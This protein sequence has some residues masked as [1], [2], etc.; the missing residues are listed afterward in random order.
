MFLKKINIVLILMFA[1]FGGAISFTSFNTNKVNAQSCNCANGQ[2]SD[3]GCAANGC[4][5]GTR[6]V[7]NCGG[8]TGGACT[9]VYTSNPPQVGVWSCYCNSDASCNASNPPV[10]PPPGGNPPVNPPPGNPPPPACSASAPG[11]AVL[12]TPANGTTIATPTSATLSWN[13]PASW[14]TGCPQNNSYRL[15]T[16]ANCSGVYV[17]RGAAN[18][19]VNLTGLSQN[20]QY[21]WYV[22]TNNGS[23][24]V[25]SVVW[26]FRTGSIPT[27]TNNGFTMADVCGRAAVGRP[28]GSNVTN[29]ISIRST[30]TSSKTITYFDMIFV[31]VPRSVS[32]NAANIFVNTAISQAVNSMSFAMAVNG[33]VPNSQ[34]FFRNAAAGVGSGPST[35]G[36]LASPNNVATAMNIGSGTR[37][38][39]AGN[40]GTIDMQVRLENNFG[41]G[42]TNPTGLWDLY[43]IAAVNH[44]DGTSAWSNESANMTRIA[45]LTVDM[46]LPSASIVGPTYNANG[47]F[48]MGFNASDNLQLQAYASYVYTTDPNPAL[49]ELT[50]PKTI[51][52][53]TVPTQ[54]ANDFEGGVGAGVTTFNTTRIYEDIGTN[55]GTN[56]NYQWDVLDGACNLVSSSTTA[57]EPSPWILTYNSNASVNGTTINQGQNLGVKI[58]DNSSLT[59]SG[60]PGFTYVNGAAGPYFTTYST[61]SGTA[62]N[63]ARPN[64]N[65]SK[66]NKFV[67]GYLNEG[68]TPQIG[69]SWYDYF[70]PIV[71]SN[72]TT[73][74]QTFATTAEAP[75]A[76]TQFPNGQ[77]YTGNLSTIFGIAANGK[78]N[79]DATGNIWFGPGTVCDI[80][81]V[82]FVS[83]NFRIGPPLTTTAGNGCV[84]IAKGNISIGSGTS[85]PVIPVTSTAQPNY[86]IVEAI[87][88]SDGF[89]WADNNPI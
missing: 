62:Q 31:M 30:L 16:S 39:W 69:T 26:S 15:F 32:G 53:T 47:T 79:I 70:K 40:T 52:V 59:I 11:Q 19:G 28:G 54:P 38:T 25:N 41:S 29:P 3:Q 61:M 8:G 37:A 60:L 35:S 46:I 63:V 86:D 5:V 17:D 66:L 78:R 50:T 85:G 57:S 36:N 75:V 45:T 9:P 23:I 55:P 4:P 71:S 64:G 51:A 6:R 87:L 58:P 81:A 43:T 88:I 83:G 67:L 2:S 18:P 80:K 84:I 42:V 74:M 20:T 44:S 22:Q 73:A 49:R 72:S 14:G 10:T 48:N 89:V 13:A 76:N 65:V 24:A 34:A 1:L 77:Q 21:C 33:N 7:C 27:L 56:F 82:I 12:T 68:A